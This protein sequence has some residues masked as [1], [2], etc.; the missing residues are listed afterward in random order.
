MGGQKAGDVLVLF[1]AYFDTD[2]HNLDL[3]VL[4]AEELAE[5]KHKYEKLVEIEA[6][7]GVHTETLFIPW[8]EVT[9]KV[10]TDSNLVNALRSLIRILRKE[11]LYLG[12]F[13]FVDKIIEDY[14]ESGLPPYVPKPMQKKCPLKHPNMIPIIKND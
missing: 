5:I 13:E 1:D 7:L 11:D 12:N 10:I 4:T 9:I 6:E 2:R 8:D 14:D 3:I